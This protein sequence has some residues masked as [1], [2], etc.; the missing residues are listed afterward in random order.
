[1]LEQPPEGGPHLLRHRRPLSPPRKPL[2]WVE[3]GH[4]GPIPLFVDDDVHRQMVAD[5]EPLAAEVAQ[6]D[7]ALPDPHEQVRAPGR[8]PDAGRG[9]HLREDAEPLGAHRDPRP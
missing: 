1:M 9:R 6:G 5:V 4:H 2:D 8:L 7:R 3:D